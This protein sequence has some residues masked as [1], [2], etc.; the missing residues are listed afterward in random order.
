MASNSDWAYGMSRAELDDFVEWYARDLESR[1]DVIQRGVDAAAERVQP[2][3]T[4][5]D[6]AASVPA[7]RP[8]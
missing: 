3:M 5:S 7:Q 6:C 2:P 8:S 4:L 1:V